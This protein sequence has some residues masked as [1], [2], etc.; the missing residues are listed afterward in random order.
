MRPGTYVLLITSPLN[1]LLNYL[2]IHPLGFGLLGAPLATGISYWL[3]FL[4]LVLYARLVAGW[5][6]WGGW[7]RAAF[8]NAG[9]F[10]RLAILGVVHVGTEWWAFEIVAIVAGLLGT[11]D[12]A[13]QS[14]IMTADQVSIPP[15]LP[16][17][18]HF[19][20]PTLLSTCDSPARRTYI[21]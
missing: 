12:L 5:A 14:V 18:L 17:P 9:T 15:S 10:A 20:V 1:A 3:S 7:S 21:K 19:S 11:I 16:A 4:L 2:F 13:S 8:A 6:A